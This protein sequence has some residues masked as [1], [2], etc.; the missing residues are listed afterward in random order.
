MAKQS[1]EQIVAELNGRQIGYDE[2]M[3]DKEL[4]ELLKKAVD[5]EK[6]AEK[7]AKEKTRLE[8]NIDYSDIRCGMSTIQELHRRLTIVER[9]LGLDK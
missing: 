5:K 6:A 9:Q 2:K 3:E 4:A 1:R 7:A 8:S